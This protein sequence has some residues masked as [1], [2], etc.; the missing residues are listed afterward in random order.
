MPSSSKERL[1]VKVPGLQ[2][3]VQG[4]QIAGTGAGQAGTELRHHAGLR[5]SWLAPCWVMVAAQGHLQALGD[6][7]LS[8]GWH[9]NFLLGAAAATPAP[10][11]TCLKQRQVSKLESR[12]A[13]GVILGCV[14]WRRPSSSRQ[15]QGGSFLGKIEMAFSAPRAENA[16]SILRFRAWWSF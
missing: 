1:L 14:G 10:T 11:C 15:Q 8:A 6:L 7:W 5:A 12:Q 13:F 2:K 9:S 4:G 3:S 16:I